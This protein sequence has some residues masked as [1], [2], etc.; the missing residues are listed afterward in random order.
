MD[1]EIQPQEPDEL[2]LVGY[3]DGG[4][5]DSIPSTTTTE[6]FEAL[7]SAKVLYMIGEKGAWV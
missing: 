5:D 7:P 2:D 4:A 3:T 6:V 1:S